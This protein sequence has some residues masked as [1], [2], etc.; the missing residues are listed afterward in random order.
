MIL[1]IAFAGLIGVISLLQDGRYRREAL[2][3][4]HR[5]PNWE[6]NLERFN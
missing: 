6:H 1:F 4:A 3:R 2:E 5:D